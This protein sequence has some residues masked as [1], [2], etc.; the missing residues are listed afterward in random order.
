MV[1][2]SFGKVSVVQIE[3]AVLSQASWVDEVEECANGIL[4][5]ILVMGRRC[6]ITPVL[7]TSVLGS[8]SPKHSSTFFPI[9]LA[10]SSPPFPVTAFAHPEF[11]T[12]ARIPSPDRVC[13]TSRDTVTG[14]AW[15]LFV[16]KTAAPE[17][18]TS[19]ATRAR[20]GKRVFD[21]LTPTCVPD[22]TKPL[23]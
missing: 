3:R 23:G 10:S 22:T 4:V 15:N 21:G 19:E 18:G 8:E 1:E 16:V 12:S 9:A 6:P 2:R 17:H 13:N 20:S 11:T 14:A 7:M 5:R